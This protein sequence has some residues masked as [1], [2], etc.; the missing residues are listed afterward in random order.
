ME[1]YG[2]YVGRRYRIGQAGDEPVTA[3]P[4]FAKCRRKWTFRPVW[5]GCRLSKSGQGYTVQVSGIRGATV[6]KQ[7]RSAAIRPHAAG[8]RKTGQLFSPYAGNLSLPA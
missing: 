2:W 7:P 3:M 8:R 5:T 4:V 1:R 6:G